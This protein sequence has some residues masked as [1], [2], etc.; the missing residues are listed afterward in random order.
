MRGRPGCLMSQMNKMDSV[1]LAAGQITGRSAARAGTR[2]K[3]FIRLGNQYSIEKVIAALR[4]SCAVGRI[5]VVGSQEEL[6]SR[7]IVQQVDAVVEGEE[8]GLCNVR[9]ALGWRLDFGLT[10]IC[11]LVGA[12]FLRF[13]RERA[14][15]PGCER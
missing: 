2:F 13:V 6:T 8:S 1:V 15:Q 12:Y 11:C 3:C 7:G 10:V 4:G 9:R 5:V 14:G